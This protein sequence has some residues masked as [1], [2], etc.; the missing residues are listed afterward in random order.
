[1]YDS[2]FLAETYRKNGAEESQSEAYAR[3]F[4]DFKDCTAIIWDVHDY[5]NFSAAPE[6]KKD[7][8]PR[9]LQEHTRNN[10]V[11]LLKKKWRCSQST[12]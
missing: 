3:G 6:N 2:I 1:V 5:E 7:S 10:L 12:A 4:N 11:R 8:T 9:K